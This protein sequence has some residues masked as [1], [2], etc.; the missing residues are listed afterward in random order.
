MAYTLTIYTHRPTGR[1]RPAAEKIAGLIFGDEWQAPPEP[2]TW[3]CQLQIWL[4]N[5]TKRPA[6]LSPAGRFRW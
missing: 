4:P 2:A 6:R 3:A 5:Q 1:D